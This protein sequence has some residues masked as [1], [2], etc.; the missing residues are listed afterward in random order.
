MAESFAETVAR[1]VSEAESRQLSVVREAAQDMAVEANTPREKGGRLPVDTS[2]LRSTLRAKR[3]NKPRGKGENTGR[4]P[5]EWDAG[6]IALTLQ[7]L[8]L[9]DRLVMGWTANY[10]EYMEARYMF[11]RSAAQQ[12]PQFVEGAAKRVYRRASG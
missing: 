5:R 3:N 10:A 9:G 8:Q 4:A 12:W 7:R 1:W 6:V 2:F 11:M